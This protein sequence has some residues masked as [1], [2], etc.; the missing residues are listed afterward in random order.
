MLKNF[1]VKGFRQF[2][3]EIKFDLTAGNFAFN[4]ECIQNKIVQTALIYGENATGKSTIG[5]AIFDLVEHLT[6]NNTVGLPNKNYINA[7]SELDYAE[8]NYKFEIDKTEIIYKYRKN[9]D[10]KIIKEELYINDNLVVN[11]QLGQ[12][13][14]VKLRGAESLNKNINAELNLSSIKYIFSNTNLDKR[15]KA[16]KTFIAFIDFV[17][18]M[19]WFRNLSDGIN[20]IG[21]RTDKSSILT[22]IVKNGNLKDFEKFLN[23]CGI[24]CKLVSMDSDGEKSIGF[25]F[26]KKI[27]PFFSIASTG[28]KSLMMFYYWWQEVRENKTSL[29]FLDEFDSSYHFKLSKHIVCMLK[30]LD[31]QVILTTH[32]TALLSNSLIRPDCGFVI[33]GSRI[34]ALHVSTLKEIRVAHNLEKLYRAG[35]FSD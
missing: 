8:F 4:E 28:T 27:L 21:N 7:D 2:K 35:E 13:V 30:E 18:N 31:S 9:K 15:N 34:N 19:L 10:K 16:N 17:S 5:W 1:S 11:Y 23:N 32:N 12:P 3:D 14:E 33:D 20:Y 29:L 6:D 22:S 25:K 24:K 26:N